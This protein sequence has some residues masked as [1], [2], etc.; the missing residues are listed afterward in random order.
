[1]EGLHS[2]TEDIIKPEQKESISNDVQ[3]ELMSLKESL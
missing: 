2:S 3:N 1:M